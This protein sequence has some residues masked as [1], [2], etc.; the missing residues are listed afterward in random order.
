MILE[1]VL[2]TSINITRILEGKE[3]E[4]GLEAFFFLIT[5]NFSKQMKDF[6]PHIQLMQ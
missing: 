4:K 3:K 5:Q 1:S 6:K 2:K